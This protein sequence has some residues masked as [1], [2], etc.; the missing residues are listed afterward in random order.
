MPTLDGPAR[1]ELIL[2]N[3]SASDDALP[4]PGW[5]S[6]TVCAQLPS[7]IFRIFCIVALMFDVSLSVELL[8]GGVSVEQP[9]FGWGRSDSVSVD[10]PGVNGDI[11]VGVAVA[12]VV[13]I[14]VVT[15]FSIL[16]LFL[17]SML[18]SV[19]TLARVLFSSDDDSRFDASISVSSSPD[20]GMSMSNADSSIKSSSL[21]FKLISGISMLFSTFSEAVAVC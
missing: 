11:I 14:C 19:S 1:A 8:D 13:D 9:G 16:R 15:I 6:L 20:D 4:M 5:L 12:D 10:E 18:I 21:L 2:A 17:A 3:D 7:I